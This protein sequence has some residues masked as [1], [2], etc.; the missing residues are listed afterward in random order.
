MATLN[1][2]CNTAQVGLWLLGPSLFSP[3]S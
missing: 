3:E 1:E 2:S